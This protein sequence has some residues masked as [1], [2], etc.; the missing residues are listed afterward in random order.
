MKRIGINDK[1]IGCGAEVD[2]PECECEWRTCSCCGYPDCF[3]YEEG[4]YYHCKIATIQLIQD[5]IC[6]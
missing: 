2:D 6:K 1:C 3:V 4:R 5:I